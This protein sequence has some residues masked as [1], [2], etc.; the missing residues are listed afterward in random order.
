MIQTNLSRGHTGPDSE[1][2]DCELIKPDDPGAGLI[3]INSQR[4]SGAPCFAGTRVPIKHMFD[5]L[6][7]GE[8][9]EEFLQGFPGISREQ[10]VGVLEIARQRLFD[11][12]PTP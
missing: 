7:A 12:L 5:Y 3:S 1:T 10:A 8:P 11:G 4:L 6:E 2:I 9:L